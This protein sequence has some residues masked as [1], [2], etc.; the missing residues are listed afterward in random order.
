ME[1]YLSREHSDIE[2][3]AIN[4]KEFYQLITSPTGKGRY[5]IDMDDFII[6]TSE[7]DYPDVKGFSPRNLRRMR[8]FYR[9]YEDAPEA[10][11]EAMTIGWTQNV[12]ILE[13][14]ESLEE[15]VWYIRAVR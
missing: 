9:A 2:W 10:L 7:A 1:V 4:G 11:A 8:D 15:R 13:G 14:C 12:A 6:E 3:I 5:F